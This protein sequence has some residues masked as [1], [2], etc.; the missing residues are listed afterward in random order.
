M[1]NP[2]VH[3]F[4]NSLC[5]PVFCVC[6][7]GKKYFSPRPSL[8]WGKPLKRGSWWD[9]NC[10]QK[11]PGVTAVR[12]KLVQRMVVLGSEP[13][14]KSGSGLGVALPGTWTMS[15]SMN[16][17]LDSL[18]S[19]ISASLN[20][21]SKFAVSWWDHWAFAQ[22]CWSST[23][24]KPCRLGPRI[25]GLWA[26]GGGVL[27]EGQAAS[28]G[29]IQVVVTRPTC[30]SSWGKWPEGSCVHQTVRPLLSTQLPFWG[31]ELLCL[32]E[33]LGSSGG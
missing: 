33:V 25:F 15:R 9:L 28:P 2:I 13:Q 19:D 20:S 11:N 5:L 24:G 16:H 4:P 27:A 10:G 18:S 7:F 8:R 21:G 17:T 30:A 32:L 22:K 31:P 1:S 3:T 14:R 29:T 6:P 23:L 26:R 12:C